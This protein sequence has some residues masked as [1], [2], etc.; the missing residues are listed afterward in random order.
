MDSNLEY[1]ILKIENPEFTDTIFVLQ[2][3]FT[4][5]KEKFVENNTSIKKMGRRPITQIF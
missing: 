3:F 4:Y 1:D 2:Q 5:R